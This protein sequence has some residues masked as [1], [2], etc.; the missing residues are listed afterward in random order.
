M[1]I[2][3]VIP[4]FNV[5]KYVSEALDSVLAQTYPDIEIICVD[6]GS[7]DNTALILEKYLRKHPDK[8]KII[9]QKNSGAPA[10]RNAGLKIAKGE[11]IQFLDADDLLLPSKIE[12]QVNLILK[13]KKK[14]DFVAGNEYWRKLDG[15]EIVDHQFSDDPWYD[16]VH[17][18]L[19]YTC[20]NLWNAGSLRR[21][22]GWNENLK[23]SQEIDIIFRLLK[24]DSV[25]LYDPEP[26]TV[27]RQRAAGSISLQS[28]KENLTRFLQVRIDVKNYL[29]QKN[30]LTARLFDVINGILFVGLKEL[31]TYDKELAIEIF[32]RN[33]PAS[34][35]LSSANKTSILYK[36][37]FLIFG[38]KLTESL[39]GFLK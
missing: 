24:E 35:V 38:F 29:I 18:A 9:S 6:N 31:F 2:S 11:F 34:F 16:L 27:N 14:P 10:A 28:R 23:S 32:S 19:G 1:F 20:S 17:G 12:H 8:I 33:I 26:L 3:V 36:L 25:I 21:I 37:L 4:C 22:N 30:M 39:V 15:T 5:D 7:A 13:G